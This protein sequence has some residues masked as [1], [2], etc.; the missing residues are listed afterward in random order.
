MIIRSDKP[1]VIVIPKKTL[2]DT[3]ISCGARGLLCSFLSQLDG[4]EGDIDPDT[5]TFEEWGYLHE[6]VDAGYVLTEVDPTTN[7]PCYTVFD[8][9]MEKS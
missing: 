8:I 2:Q 3:S 7:I 9:R 5:L 1:S 6:L 4:E